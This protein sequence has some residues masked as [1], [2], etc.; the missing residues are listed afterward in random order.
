VNASVSRTESFD[1]EVMSMRF[2][3]LVV[4]ALAAQDAFGQEPPKIDLLYQAPD[5]SIFDRGDCANLSK[6]PIRREWVQ[7]TV[8]R[9]SEFQS[10]WDNDGVKYLRAALAEIG[11]PFPYSE[12]QAYLTV[13]PGVSSKSDPLLLNVGL[14][15]SDAE[16]PSPLWMFALLTYHEL[17]HH[18]VRP[19]LASSELLKKYGAEPPAARQH[20]HVLALEKL[21][22]V[23]VGKSDQLKYMD[24]EYRTG[25]FARSQPAYKR[26]WEIVNDIEGYEA[27]LKELKAMPNDVTHPK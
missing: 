10:L 5:G 9:R 6:T 15:M 23:K 25:F 4:L 26:A 18:Y 16:M 20:L 1:L 7:E 24:S 17:M 14:F 22:L 3:L 13:C 21:A 19:V 12:M 2:V 11:A 8:K 27:F